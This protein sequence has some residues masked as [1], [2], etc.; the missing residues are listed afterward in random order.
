MARLALWFFRTY[1]RLIWFVLGVLPGNLLMWA[2]H[3]ACAARGRSPVPWPPIVYRVA[4]FVLTTLFI[5]G[6][7]AFLVRV[8]SISR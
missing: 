4:G 8:G 3:R 6:I 1:L 2:H 5:S 7:N